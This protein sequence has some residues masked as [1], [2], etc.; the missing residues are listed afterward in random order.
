[1]RS[2]RTN[3]G[4][5]LALVLTVCTASFAQVQRID[6]RQVTGLVSMG[7]QALQG[8]V[9][10]I[11]VSPTLRVRTYITQEDGL[12]SFSSLQSHTDYLLWAS[13]HGRRSKMKKI[14][15]FDRALDRK[16]LL[17]IPEH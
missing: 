11:K 3:F 17:V 15:H 2:L 13:Y 14:S 12:Y 9:V 1:M 4:I 7:G 6:R 8:A 10:Y 5:G 16:I